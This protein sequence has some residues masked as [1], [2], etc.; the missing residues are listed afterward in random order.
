VKFVLD[1]NIDK[2]SKFKKLLIRDHCKTNI[3]GLRQFSME[4][5]NGNT[6]MKVDKVKF[7]GVIIDE[8]LSWDYQVE[9]LRK[10]THLLY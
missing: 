5:S 3:N 1:F 6:L 7:L 2:A 10:K 4:N 8:E 9:H